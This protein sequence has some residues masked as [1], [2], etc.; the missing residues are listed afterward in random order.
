MSTI[1]ARRASVKCPLHPEQTLRPL[2]YQKMVAGKVCWYNID[3]YYCEDCKDVFK[4]K[5]TV[6][7]L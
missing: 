4:I 7:I 5:V 6:E 2:R 3:H 1:D